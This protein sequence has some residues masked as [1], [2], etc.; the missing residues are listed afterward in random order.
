MDEKTYT[1]T[2]AH[3]HFAIDFHSQTWELMEKAER[4]PEDDERMENF[5]HA[6]LAHWRTAGTAVRRQRGEWLLARVYALLDQPQAAL[7]HAYRCA[8]IFHANLDEMQDFDTAFVYEGA[9]RAHAIA[10]DW[11][12][13]QRFMI[14]ARD[15]GEKIADPEDR[16]IFFSQFR[17]GP[18]NGMELP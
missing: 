7:K 16:E 3:L 13:A 11:K 1:V 14:K 2:Q 8:E 9:A 15:A 6:S 17:S 18:W 10:D 5:A 12:E 4:T